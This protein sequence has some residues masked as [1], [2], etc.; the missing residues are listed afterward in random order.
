M[1]FVSLFEVSLTEAV[2]LAAR[3]VDTASRVWPEA[4]SEGAWLSTYSCCKLFHL[5]VSRA[6]N[7]SCGLF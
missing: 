3:S 5:V 2:S 1:T 4:D 6:C 7:R